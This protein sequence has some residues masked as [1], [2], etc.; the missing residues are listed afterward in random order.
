MKLVSS[1]SIIDLEGGGHLEKKNITLTMVVGF[2]G[3][4]ERRYQQ[5]QRTFK[6]VVSVIGS[7]FVGATQQCVCSINVNE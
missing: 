6:D 5:H 3:N 7:L 1:F 2:V 4:G